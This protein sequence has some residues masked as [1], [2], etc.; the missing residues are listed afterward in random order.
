MNTKIYEGKTV[1]IYGAG[2]EGNRIYGCLLNGNI[3]VEAFCDS[4]EKKQKI[5]KDGVPVLSLESLRMLQK[6]RGNVLVQIGVSENYQKEVMN[7]LGNDFEIVQLSEAKECVESI[8]RNEKKKFASMN[9][10][11][12]DKCYLRGEKLSDG[13][14]MD[15]TLK[16]IA[17]NVSLDRAGFIVAQCKNKN[18]LHVGACDHEDLIKDKINRGTWLQQQIEEE[19]NSVVGVDI[20]KSAV[21]L[22]QSLGVDSVY[23]YDLIKD[24]KPIIE[25]GGNKGY[26][27]MVLGE[28]LEHL[29]NPIGF[30]SEIKKNYQGIVKEMII[31]VPNALCYKN[32]VQILEGRECI[33]SDHRFWF[34]PYTLAKVIISAGM[35][36]D[37]IYFTQ[38]PRKEF[39]LEEK[40]TSKLLGF[41]GFSEEENICPLSS[42]LI[43]HF[44]L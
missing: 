23:F 5:G 24:I 6:E 18:V 26:D 13:Y 12:F 8:F 2:R 4:D 30:L 16:G 42:T 34:T 31:S 21:E 33:N 11:S 32:F 19:A 43:A 44:K 40:M 29:D 35:D 20:N 17:E 37:N 15:C 25:L 7:L 3:H 10:T 27:I 39:K 22:C 41:Y 36:L 9:I 14:S 1:V 28:M 38:F